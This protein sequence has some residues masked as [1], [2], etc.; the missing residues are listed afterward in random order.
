LHVEL[1]PLHFKKKNFFQGFK[2][3]AD[4]INIVYDCDSYKIMQ[5]FFFA[6]LS[7]PDSKC[8]MSAI[9]IPFFPL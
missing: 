4:L 6:I 1:P 9:V 7:S 5:I 8:Y 3:I 2:M